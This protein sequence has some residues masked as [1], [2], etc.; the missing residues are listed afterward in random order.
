MDTKKGRMYGK[1]TPFNGAP[2]RFG[3]AVAPNCPPWIRHWTVLSLIYCYNVT[4]SDGSSL[5]QARSHGGYSGAVPFKFLLCPPNFVAPRKICFEHIVKQ[6][7]WPPKNILFSTKPWNL[8]TGLACT[9]GKQHSS[10]LKEEQNINIV[11]VE[12]VFHLGYH[13]CS[14]CRLCSLAQHCLTDQIDNTSVANWYIYTKFENFGIFSKCL[15]YKSL[16][17]YT[18]KIWY[19]FDRGF[20]R[21]FKSMYLL[22]Y[23]AETEK[24]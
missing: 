18:W 16:I 12:P 11:V 7:P 4:E 6:K 5:Y 19:I 8:A 3:G 1:E 17:W 10:L 14:K 22:S 9:A 20:S 21:D 13:S 2:Q 23:K 15:V 24:T